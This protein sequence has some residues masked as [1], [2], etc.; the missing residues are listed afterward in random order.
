MLEYKF[1]QYNRLSNLKLDIEKAYILKFGSHITQHN[2]F[3]GLLI[4][5]LNSLGNELSSPFLR[6]FII[7]GIGYRAQVTTN[8]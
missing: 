8:N 1:G 4:N 5:N 7:R 3:D 2:G 6:T